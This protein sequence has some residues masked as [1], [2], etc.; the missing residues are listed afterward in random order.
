MVTKVKHLTAAELERLALL[1]EEC[2]EVLQVI[3]KILRFGWD[4]NSPVPH[5]MGQTINRNL[6]ERELG[7]LLL[8][9]DHIM[10]NDI[11]RKNVDSRMHHKSLKINGFLKHNVV[12]E[13]GEGKYD[14]EE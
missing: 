4:S 13:W 1:Q 11:S 6:L 2:G 3:G 9:A 5:E 12:D 8:V 10:K 7:D 14:E